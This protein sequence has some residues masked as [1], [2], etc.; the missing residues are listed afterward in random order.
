MIAFTGS[1]TTEDLGHPD[2][3]SFVRQCFETCRDLIGL[4]DPASYKYPDLQTVF[5]QFRKRAAPAGKNASDQLDE[6]ARRLAPLVGLS[7]V[8]HQAELAAIQARLQTLGATVRNLV[9][10]FDKRVAFSILGELVD[11]FEEREGAPCEERENEIIAKAHFLQ[12]TRATAKNGG[13]VCRLIHELGINRFATLNY[14]LELE[15]ALALQN[16]ASPVPDGKT[17]I[18]ILKEEAQLEEDRDTHQLRATLADGRTIVSDV[19]NRE[20]TDRLIE[21]AVRSSEIDYHVFHLHGR[22]DHPKSMII[23]YRDY[24]RLYRRSDLTRLPFEHALR[25]LFAGNP[26]L[27]VGIGMNETEINTTLQNFVGN[28]PYLRVTPTFLLWNAPGGS[29][30]EADAAKAVMRL[31][32]LH[33][34]GV[35]T[36]FDDELDQSRKAVL[37]ASARMAESVSS[38]AQMVLK[39]EKKR[40]TPSLAFRSI[41]PRIDEVEPGKVFHTWRVLHGNGY[42]PSPVAEV[43]GKSLAGLAASPVAERPP[44][45]VRIAGSG[46]GKGSAAQAYAENWLDAAKGEGWEPYAVIVNAGFCFDTDTVLNFIARLIRKL[47]ST[48]DGWKKS[49][50]A[51]MEQF[52]QQQAFR[53]RPRRKMLIVINGADRLFAMNGSPLSAEFDQLM[54]EVVHKAADS[55]IQWLILGTERIRPYFAAIQR[56]DPAS[57]DVYDPRR[58]KSGKRMPSFYLKSVV[59]AFADLR[60][61]VPLARREII[62]LR[63]HEDLTT[64]RRTVF[65][66]Y[67][68]KSVLTKAG[69]DADLAFDIIQVL[70]FIGQPVEAAVLFH[71]PRIARRLKK[72]TE[73]EA[74]RTLF[75]ETIAKLYDRRLLLKVDRFPGTGL[76]R[77]ALHRALLTEMRE[78]FGVPLSE[79]VLSTAFNMSLY[80]AQPADST[81]PEARLHD[82]LGEL[83]DHLVGAFKDEPLDPGAELGDRTGP[84]ASAALRAALSVVRGLYSTTTLLALDLHDR[85]FLEGREGALTEH[86]ERLNRILLAFTKFCKELKGGKGIGCASPFYADELVWLHNELGV[87][88]LVQGDLYAARRSFE[89]A[90]RINEDHVEFAFRG[91]NWRRINLNQIAVD[92]DRGKGD[93]VVSRIGDIEREIGIRTVREITDKFALKPSPTRYPI[94]PTFPHEH[95]LAVALVRGHRAVHNHV[96]GELV[97]AQDSMNKA[98]FIL[99]QLNERRAIA[100]F[101]RHLASVFDALRLS[102]KAQEEVELAVIVAESVRQMDV[103]Y[104]GRIQRAHR[105]LL[106]DAAKLRDANIYLRQALA[107]ADETDMHRVRVE[108]RAALALLKLRMGDHEAALENAADALATASRYGLSLRKI[109]LRIV[110]GRILIA[111]G[112]PN[113]GRALINAAIEEADRRGYQSALRAAQRALIELHEERPGQRP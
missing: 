22:A 34:L 104:H 70:A 98:I 7:A 92:I 72:L 109:S 55:D 100:L 67:L 58:S 36:L 77:Y 108:A 78:R 6:V 95:I 84:H 93:S 82:E 68:D 63:T 80:Y 29:K 64:I 99:R 50:K 38:L 83:V 79:A 54:R 16:P 89:E 61:D 1:F 96:R 46:A 90:H 33:R 73:L 85:Y 18:D 74:R 28:H 13:T 12:R 35:L 59:E 57:Y 26:I 87:V 32:M 88:K 31:D 19:F 43:L 20:R 44:L 37:P 106:H 8:P 111:R 45:E 4:D 76:D 103:V 81:L 56:R 75:N 107:Y 15:L 86:A 69:M 97:K 21:F 52:A 65:E 2:W 41:D 71:A 17:A 14:D 5:E 25:I 10:G 9:D 110:I 24:D 102:Q 66:A 62:D 105:D 48:G 27:F 60:R 30:E 39:E 3:P 40:K 42:R 91:H 47:Q 53:L 51:R 94:D 112:D 49:R 11:V 113:S 101:R 23:S